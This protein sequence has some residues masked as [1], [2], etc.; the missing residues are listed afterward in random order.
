MNIRGKSF[1]ELLVAHENNK[2]ARGVIV[3][4]KRHYRVYSNV[5]M[6]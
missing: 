1:G 4:G 3:R 2:L 6:P 5:Y